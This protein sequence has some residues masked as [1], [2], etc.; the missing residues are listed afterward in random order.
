[1][2]AIRTRAVDRRVGACA[3]PSDACP[4]SGRLPGI[5]HLH[6]NCEVIAGQEFALRLILDVL[7]TDARQYVL[8]PR[9]GRLARVA[10]GRGV[11]DGR[12]PA[13]AA[14]TQ[15]SAPVL[16]RNTATHPADTDPAD[17]PDPCIGRLSQSTR[18]T[19]RPADR[20][21]SG[22]RSAQRDLSAGRAPPLF[23][24][25]GAPGCVRVERCEGLRA[26]RGV[27]KEARHPVPGRRSRPLC[28]SAR[29]RRRSAANSGFR[30]MRF[31]W[32]NSASSSSASGPPI[33][34]APPGT[35]RIAIPTSSS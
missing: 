30:R 10:Q 14:R 25:S 35:S 17:R 32:G 8:L 21:E 9:E 34:S 16:A 12:P 6:A 20:A 24:P 4:M 15:A 26:R 18:G 28:R 31:F 2:R 7:K 33:S 13:R 23:R 22:L 5:L 29:L 3:P 27:R 1:M 11:R 19:G